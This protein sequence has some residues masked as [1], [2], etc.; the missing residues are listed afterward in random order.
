MPSVTITPRQI[1]IEDLKLTTSPTQPTSNQFVEG[2]GTVPL[3]LIDM[4][5]YSAFGQYV[6]DAA[7][8][9]AGLALGQ[10]Y[11]NTTLQALKSKTS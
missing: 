6:N 5:R 9:V 4:I 11:F 7:A 10:I 2:V 8:T 1:F 3:T